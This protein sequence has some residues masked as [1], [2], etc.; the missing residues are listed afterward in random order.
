M[1][2]IDNSNGPNQDL[3]E[4]PLAEAERRATGK[5]RMQVLKESKAKILMTAK[6]DEQASNRK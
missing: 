5:Q 2:Y 4:Q 1:E 3:Q 6:A